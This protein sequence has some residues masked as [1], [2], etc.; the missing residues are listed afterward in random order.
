MKKLTAF[1]LIIRPINVL[2]G[3]FSIFMGAFITGTITPLMNVFLASLSG[4]FIAGAANAINDY[5]DVE[6]DRI[7]KPFRPIP[8]GKLSRHEVLIFSILL[9]ILGILI[10]C[11]VNF[12]AF[13]IAFSS[14][15][16]LF[17]YSAYLKR[18]VLW[19]NLC[20]SL[21]T[22][23]AFIYGGAA[24]DRFQAALIPALFSFLFH[25]GREIIKDVQDMAG[26]AADH[27]VTFPIRFGK[28]VSLILASVIY[29]FLIIVT[30]MPFYYKIYGIYYL[31]VVLVGVDL[32]IVG[33]L[34]S[35]W[36]DQTPKNLGRMSNLLK[37]DMLIGLIAIFCGRI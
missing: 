31:A 36:Q 15:I 32:V 11:L 24:V 2:I 7:N 22:A 27:A 33:V 25:F 4:G 9:F 26:D 5:F 12:L 16:L 37:A 18:T 1:L 29:I 10:S 19:G 3:Y 14:S 17:L 6:I 21:V 35:I 34:I 13:L 8:A 30:F 23:L 28:R 20:V